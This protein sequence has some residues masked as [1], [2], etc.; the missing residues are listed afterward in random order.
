MASQPTIPTNLANPLTTQQIAGPNEKISRAVS[1]MQRKLNDIL[2]RT[3]GQR[4]ALIRLSYVQDKYFNYS[5]SMLSQMVTYAMINFPNEEVP[6]NFLTDSMPKSTS[7]QQT[8]TSTNL[9][10]AYDLLPITGRFLFSDNVQFKDII[11]FKL[12]MPNGDYQ[13]IQLQLN[14]AIARAT[15]SD[16]IVQEWELAPPTDST[17]LTN[18]TYQAIVN[19]F[20]TTDLW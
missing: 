18:S 9:V 8:S 4:V 13:V 3:Q 7:T 1:Y 17:I 5:Q 12:K 15:I 19:Y 16:I 11:L 10:H 20:K 2:V 14:D 6:M